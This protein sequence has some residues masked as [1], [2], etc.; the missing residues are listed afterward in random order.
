M[1][2]TFQ[3][4]LHEHFEI[5]YHDS[6]GEEKR[7]VCGANTLEWAKNFVS[8]HVEADNGPVSITFYARVLF[9]ERG[10]FPFTPNRRFA[11]TKISPEHFVNLSLESMAQLHGQAEAESEKYIAEVYIPL[12]DR[13]RSQRE[14][15]DSNTALIERES[16][17]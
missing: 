8:S 13:A 4:F 1:D 5:T 16:N 14:E 10:K 12:R 9:E 3:T 17:R 7:E 15:S 6:R 11:E 2:P